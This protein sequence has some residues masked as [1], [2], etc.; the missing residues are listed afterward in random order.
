MHTQERLKIILNSDS[1]KEYHMKIVDA[2]K[3]A[4]TDFNSFTSVFSNLHIKN[5]AEVKLYDSAQSIRF[6]DIEDE[7]LYDGMNFHAPNLGFLLYPDLETVRK[8]ECYANAATFAKDMTTKGDKDP[9]KFH[10]SDHKEGCKYL[11]DCS[12]EVSLTDPAEIFTHSV[13]ECNKM[14]SFLTPLDRDIEVFVAETTA[15]LHSAIFEDKS[16]L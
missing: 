14:Y 5:D 7:L 3:S 1:V 9:F 11:K 8:V 2:L 6:S 15:I 12:T 4:N 13:V 10:I 16:E